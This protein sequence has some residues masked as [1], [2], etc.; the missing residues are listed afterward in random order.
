MASVG[1]VVGTFFLVIELVGKCPADESAGSGL[2]NRPAP[3][4]LMLVGFWWRQSLQSRELGSIGMVLRLIQY[5][6]SDLF[7]YMRRH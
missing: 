6:G 4:H 2:L 1:G 5:V 3:A 7:Y